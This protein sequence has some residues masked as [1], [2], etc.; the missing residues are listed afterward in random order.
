MFEIL[1]LTGLQSQP[2]QCSFPSLCT[3]SAILIL[4]VWPKIQP[5]WWHILKQDGGIFI[6]YWHL[7][8]FCWCDFITDNRAVLHQPRV[9]PIPDDV[10]EQ[11]LGKQVYAE[12]PPGFCRNQDTFSQ[13][14]SRDLLKSKPDFTQKCSCL[15]W[16]QWGS[17]I[18][19]LQELGGAEPSMPE[20]S[21]GHRIWPQPTGPLPTPQGLHPRHSLSCGLPD[22]FQ[23][24]SRLWFLY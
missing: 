23:N 4:Q 8:D 10:S 12:Y 17:G 6:L 13:K 16:L 21:R 24:A 20:D 15:L 18:H 19:W 5:K 7:S 3:S 22:S 11:A 2:P 14:F 1:I 9:S